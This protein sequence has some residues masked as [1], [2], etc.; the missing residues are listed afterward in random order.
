MATDGISGAAKAAID[1][2][3]QQAQDHS[4]VTIMVVIVGL[5]LFY[6]WRKEKWP[7]KV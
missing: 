5:Y 2:G 1:V 6:A 7:F 4:T 3:V